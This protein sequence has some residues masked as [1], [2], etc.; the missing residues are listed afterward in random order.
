MTQSSK[1]KIL[2]IALAVFT[3]KG[4][5]GASMSAIAKHAGVSKPLLYHYFPS[6]E[7]LWKQVKTDHVKKTIELSQQEGIQDSKLKDPKSLEEFLEAAIET[8]FQIYG[9][10]KEFVKIMAWQSL[11]SDKLKISGGTEYS[12]DNWETPIISLQQ[13][14]KINPLLDPKLIIIFLMSSITGFF[15]YDYLGLADDKAARD[16]YKNLLKKTFLQT[17]KP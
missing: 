12:P 3:E 1:E 16:T 5:D 13:N 2:R 6:K 10:S 14:G 4:F 8:R 11:E 9:Q 15:Q 17:L 7:D